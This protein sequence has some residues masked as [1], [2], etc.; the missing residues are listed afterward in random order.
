MINAQRGSGGGVGSRSGLIEGHS[1]G[2]EAAD[3]VDAYEGCR[4]AGAASAGEGPS[5]GL[6]KDAPR[7]AG[8]RVVVECVRCTL[9]LSRI[10]GSSWSTE[11]SEVPVVCLDRGVE[12]GF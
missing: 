10:G 12:K 8:V 1:P 3:V 5:R 4:A 9:S 7:A 2:R 11:A 6:W